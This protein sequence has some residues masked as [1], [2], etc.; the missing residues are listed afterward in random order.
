LDGTPNT[1][2]D[3]NFLPYLKCTNSSTKQIVRVLLDSGA[4]KNIIRPGII[5]DAKPIEPKNIKSFNG[6]QT[7]TKKVKANILG[8]GLPKQTFYEIEFHQ[9]F[10]AIIGSEYF[11]KTDAELNYKTETIKMNGIML[12]YKKYYP[13]KK[14]YCHTITLQ[15]IKNGDWLVPHSQKLNNQTIIEPGL[16]RSQNNE[17]KVNVWTTSPIIP[18]NLPKLGLHINNFETIEPI[19]ADSDEDL[20]REKIER[21]LRTQHLSE[22]EKIR[23]LDS[24]HQ[25]Q[26]TLLKQ[27]E[28]LSAT[29]AIKHKINTK[30]ENPVY[31]K[32]YR[33]PHHF[34]KDI[35]E[36]IQEMLLNGIIQPSNSPYNAPIWVVPKKSDASGKRKVRLVI[37]YRK[38]NEKTVDDR[39]PIP[40]IEE[41]LENLGKSEYFTTLDL[42]S[43]FH[44]IEMDLVDR[45][46]T[47]FSVDNGHYE[48]VRMPFGLKN[49]PATF[50]RVM[51]SILQGLIGNICYVYLDDI[52]V[53]GTSLENHI[54]NLNRVFERLI[55]NNLKIQ[56]DKCEFLK[57]ETEFLGHV[58]TPEGIKPNPD[59][60]KQI[61]NWPLP[62][63]QKQIKQFL[64]LAGYYRRFIK[65]YAKL[66]RPLSKYLKRDA[67][68]NTNDPEYVKA[69]KTLRDIISSDQILAYPQFDNPFILT[70]DASK[71]ALGAVLSQIQDGI[72]RPIAFASR[73]L[74]DTEV[75]YSVTEKEALAIIWAV[76]K[77]EPYLYGNKFLL[78]TD[79]KPLTFIKTS[80]KNS[81][82]LRWRLELE[83]FDYEVKYKEGKANVVADA[84]SRKIETEQTEVNNT[85]TRG[86]DLE[87]VHS[88]DTSD[89]HF[90]HISERPLNYYRNQLIFRKSSIGT[91]ITETIFPK[92]RRIIIVND[93]YSEQ[94]IVKWLKTYHDGKQTAILA[95]EDLIQPIQ[96][97]FRKHFLS[98]GHF[99]FVTK[100]VEDVVSEERQNSLIIKEHD[101]A[102]RGINEVDNQLKRAYFFPNMTKK[103]RDYINTC[104][105]CNMHKYDRKT[106]K[107]IKEKPPD[108]QENEH[109]FV[110]P[111]IKTKTPT[112]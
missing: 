86:S 19:S 8:H 53:V 18:K 69:F 82:I 59:K 99:I 46:K 2:S 16:Y 26:R 98:K 93:D 41:I 111:N 23:L 103:I 55:S 7:A 51:N 66:S 43:G 70:T 48:F 49:A 12:K 101:R 85:E 95:P 76:K 100:Q 104:K 72:E 71:Y 57:K 35:E 88:A 68:M 11:A 15:T 79:H 67:T 61:L 36:Q 50:Q 92:Y 28:K 80:E 22:L 5:P 74:N 25:N 20:S 110:I 42:K 91:V 96:E 94:N 89:D 37:D 77:Y 17:T 1:R 56:L 40:Q 60:I 24:I 54:E 106:F 34:K 75:N 97:V 58:I 84:L 39:Y 47:A 102:H 112:N 10:D 63:T 62:K 33:Y 6:T 90:I 52:I 78:I 3:L 9:F 87:T 73:T 13:A 81:K 83:K 44:Q 65:D 107:T 109:V 105:T 64:G 27:N 30:D 108:I 31:T 4:N 38:L 29:T 21:L 45:I 32:S 14:L